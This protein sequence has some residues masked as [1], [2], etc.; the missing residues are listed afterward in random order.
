M[1]TAQESSTG[2][3]ANTLL[4]SLSK[5]TRI[6]TKRNHGKTNCL[7]IMSSFNKLDLVIYTSAARITID[8][9]C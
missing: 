1:G 3:G 8:H 5:I 6:S 4:S 2:Q 7:Q 9:M